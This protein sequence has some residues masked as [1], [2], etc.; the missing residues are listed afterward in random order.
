MPRADWSLLKTEDFEVPE[1][2]EQ[3]AIAEVLSG[4]DE[5]IRLLAE[6]RAKVKPVGSLVRWMTC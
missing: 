6:E 1:V 3:Q 4:M 5:E 2:D